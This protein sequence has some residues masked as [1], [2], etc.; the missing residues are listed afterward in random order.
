MFEDFEELRMEE[1]KKEEKSIISAR[2]V[3][4][5]AGKKSKYDRVTRIYPATNNAG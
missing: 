4:F 3:C 5:A 1:R 2:S